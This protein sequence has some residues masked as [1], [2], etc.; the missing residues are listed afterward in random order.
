MSGTVTSAGELAAR[1]CT[2]RV[3]AKLWLRELNPHDLRTLQIPPLRNAFVA[4][5]GVL[6]EDGDARRLEQLA[7]DYCHLFIGPA[8][9]LPPYQSVW[10]SGRFDGDAAE[11]MDTFMQIVAYDEAAGVRR[12]MSDHLGVQL[13]VMGFMM[14]RL[15]VESTD[16]A[17]NRCLSEMIPAFFA[18]HLCWPSRLLHLAG[19]MAGTRFYRSVIAMTGEFLSGEQQA[20]RDGRLP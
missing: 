13:D 20:W 15:S 17:A 16:A 6:P 12:T 19:Q 3:L 4:A 5:G 11:S 2:Y 1:S 14:H 8:N 7:E 10:Q 9:H 18:A